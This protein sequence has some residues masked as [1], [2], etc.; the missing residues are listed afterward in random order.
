MDFMEH[1]IFAKDHVKPGVWYYGG[2]PKSDHLDLCGFPHNLSP[3]R[4][5]LNTEY[6]MEAWRNIYIRLKLLKFDD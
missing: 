2:F 4:T 6:R 1:P 3:I 5:L